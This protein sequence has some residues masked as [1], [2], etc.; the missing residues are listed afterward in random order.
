MD[1]NYIGQETNNLIVTGIIFEALIQ[2]APHRIDNEMYSQDE[3]SWKLVDSYFG[4][5][6]QSRESSKQARIVSLEGDVLIS[7]TLDEIFNY[8][9]MVSDILAR[10]VVLPQGMVACCNKKENA[11][12]TL[13]IYYGWKVQQLKGRN[14]ARIITLNEEPIIYGTIDEM[15]K[16]IEEVSDVLS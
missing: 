10:S 1:K 3:C 16:R 15:F 2:P 12:I 14:E 5:L 9:E 4:W 7:G 6:I 13:H 8:V 11:W